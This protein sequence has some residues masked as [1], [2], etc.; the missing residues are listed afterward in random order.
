MC[1]S[2]KV[3]NPD[4]VL[5]EGKIDEYEWAVTHNGIGFRC[6]Y[7]RVPAG[8]PWHGKDD[9]SL[10]EPS[11]HGGITFASADMPCGR[12]GAAEDGWWLG[13]DAAHL[14]DAPDPALPDSKKM[15][16]WKGGT[17]RTQEYMERECFRLIQQAKA[18]AS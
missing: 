16:G 7:V 14:D 6:G 2:I 8:H 15:E 10:T 13:F 17:I 4:R 1:L 11:V 18:V 9:M 5:A 12:D 3:H